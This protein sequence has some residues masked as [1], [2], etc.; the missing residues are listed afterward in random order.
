MSASPA[1]V[2]SPSVSIPAGGKTDDPA[3][4]CRRSDDLALGCP[5]SFF[6]AS[7]HVYAVVS[8]RARIVIGVNLNPD[9]YCNFDCCYREVT[10]GRWCE[11]APSR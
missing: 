1:V 6:P 9:Q 4:P 7:T 2:V 8:S 10:A 5:R 11:D 3:S